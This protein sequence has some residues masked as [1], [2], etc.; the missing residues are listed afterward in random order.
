MTDQDNDVSVVHLDVL[1]GGVDIVL[2]T[3][4]GFSEQLVVNDY[5]QI[6]DDPQSTSG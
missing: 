6:D 1:N 3:L 4:Q 5:Q 2:L